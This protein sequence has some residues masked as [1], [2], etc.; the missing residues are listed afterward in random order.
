MGPPDVLFPTA[1]LCSSKKAEQKQKGLGLVQGRR[2]V[3]QIGSVC[4]N[5]MLF[6][7]KGYAF[8]SA[9]FGGNTPYNHRSAVP[10]V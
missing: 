9:K 6:K 3:W 2:K 1:P 8:N 4:S 7:G 10:I 5:T